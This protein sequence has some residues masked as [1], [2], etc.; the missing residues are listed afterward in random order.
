[1]RAYGIQ[2]T[3]TA[4]QTA[5]G[6]VSFASPVMTVTKIGAFTVN[7]DEFYSMLTKG[8]PDI[9]PADG[10]VRS[11]AFAY[12]AFSEFKYT[13]ASV[14]LFSPSCLLPTL[15]T[16]VSAT[17]LNLAQWTEY[18]RILFTWLLVR[19]T[20]CLLHQLCGASCK[21]S[22]IEVRDGRWLTWCTN[23]ATFYQMLPQ[24]PLD[25]RW[26]VIWICW[27]FDVNSRSLNIHHF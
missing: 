24:I 3:R 2:F 19:L 5:L 17:T 7:G 11:R 25:I 27:K 10:P 6:I 15:G 21:F 16:P 13:W 8:T 22:Q 20:T 18:F 14:Q 23:M 1:M 26:K 9:L 4:T 12:D